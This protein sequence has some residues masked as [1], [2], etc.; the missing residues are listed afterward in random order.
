MDNARNDKHAKLFAKWH[1]EIDRELDRRRHADEGG[2]GDGDES[3][4]VDASA[5]PA[6]TRADIVQ[7]GRVQKSRRR[8]HA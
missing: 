4:E 1:A 3:V 5:G 6:P 7:L 2:K 8:Y